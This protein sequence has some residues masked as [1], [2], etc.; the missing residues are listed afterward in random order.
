[1]AY[2]R[3]KAKSEYAQKLRDP[4]WQKMRLEVMQRDEF[5]CQGCFDAEETLNV[6]HNYY[7]PGNAPWDYPK[8]SLVTLCETC[9]EEETSVR[10]NEEQS[11]LDTLRRIGMKAS[12]VNGLA[13]TLYQAFGNHPQF[14][15]HWGMYLDRY[16]VHFH[17]IAAE[18]E[19]MIVARVKARQAE[20]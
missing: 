17:E 18:V 5:R 2:D 9:H 7:T 12:H 13:T 1:M 14:P 16:I 19:D 20:P 8:E 10:R 4:R 3:E 6:H 15:D 11:L